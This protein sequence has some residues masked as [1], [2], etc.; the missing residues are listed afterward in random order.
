MNTKKN[1]LKTMSGLEYYRLFIKKM[2]ILLVIFSLVPIFLI[3]FV[4]RYYFLTSY[5]DKLQGHMSELVQKHKQNIDN[6]LQERLNN[7]KLLAESFTIEQLSNEEFLQKHLSLLQ[8]EYDS[9]F[10]DIGVVNNDGIQIAYAGNYKLVSANYKDSEW[11]NQVLKSKYYIS[12]VF[13]GL[14][15]QPH[16]IVAVTKQWNNKNYI[17]RATIDFNSF[18]SMVENIKIGRTGV[19][20]IVNKTG[21]LQTKNTNNL[22]TIVID[23]LNKIEIEKEEIHAVQNLKYGGKEFIFIIGSI[24]GG[25][26]RLIFQQE[27]GDAFSEVNNARQIGIMVLLFGSIGVILIYYLMSRKMIRF[28]DQSEIERQRMNEQV[29]ESG[30]LASIGELAAGIAHEINNPVAIM[31]EEAGWIQD[32]LKEEDLKDCENLQEFSRS[33]L[34]IRMQ[35]MRCKDITF[36]LLSFA[37][38]TDPRAVKIQVNNIIEEIIKLSKQRA[39]YR[40][41]TIKTEFESGLPEIMASPSELQQVFLNLF[42][43]AIDAIGTYN[44]EG[45]VTIVTKKVGENVIISFSDNG[46]GIPS[47]NISRIFD[48][49]FTTKPIGKGTGI[50]LAICHGIIQKLG[51]DI[52]VISEVDVGTTF[53]LSI[54]L[55]VEKDAEELLTE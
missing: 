55:I 47:A 36:K 42:N 49:F 52:N 38:K 41:I 9:T 26:W 40:H 34:Q 5:S 20:F 6:F 31:I 17:V 27:Q 24:K 14:R 1:N 48:P 53:E 2:V 35:G 8:K 30:K 28:I 39:R 43:N 23:F 33:L 12:D 22:Q 51:G 10:V 4:F 25:Q 15:G 19:A 32:L 29:I 46:Q 16:F 3:S 54:P 11:F 45:L 50:G 37:R 7:I 21:Q 44:D 18:N 13:L